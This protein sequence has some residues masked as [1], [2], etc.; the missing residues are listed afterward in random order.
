MISF[1]W[2]QPGAVETDLDPGALKFR[3]SQSVRDVKFRDCEFLQSGWVEAT[4]ARVSGNSGNSLYHD[5]SVSAC[6]KMMYNKDKSACL[7]TCR[8]INV[9]DTLS[10]R[11]QVHARMSI[12]R[13][14]DG[15]IQQCIDIQ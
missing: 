2:A 10:V 4:V 15:N 11:M 5:V 1:R 12:W 9:R 3:V 13:Q 6:E 14:L 7:V 8:H